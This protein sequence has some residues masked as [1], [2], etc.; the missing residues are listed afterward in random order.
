MATMTSIPQQIYAS[1]SDE[2]SLK[3]AL[4]VKQSEG[5]Y[6]EFKQKKDNKKAE[7]DDEDK[8]NFSEG[9][10]QFANS[11]G[12]V[13]IWGMETGRPN[14]YAKKLKPI[15]DIKIFQSRLSE[16]LKDAVQPMVD[17]V[18]IEPIFKLKNKKTGYLKI[19]IPQSDKTP[20]RAMKTREY[21]KRNIQGKYK[22]EHFDLEDM[23]GRR[24]KPHLS[25]SFIKKDIVAA[26][27]EA[28]G[29]FQIFLHNVG[30][31]IGRDVLVLIGPLE[32]KKIDLNFSLHGVPESRIDD[33]YDDKPTFQLNLRNSIFY[34]E[35]NTKLG[36]MRIIHKKD[37]EGKEQEIKSL[38]I[39]WNIYAENMLPKSGSEQL[40]L[41]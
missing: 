9:L 26:G 29:S 7:L 27:D 15:K 17:Q 16:Y 1:Y 2:E 12:G 35:V 41:K 37:S 11:D 30:R 32:D 13:Q 3:D 33:M 21:L 5:L 18:I 38:N 36:D 39:S 40:D 4:K 19:L 6:L 31:A 10:S 14:D 24:Q 34:P 23:F 8:K 22:L 28:I 20:H 25:L